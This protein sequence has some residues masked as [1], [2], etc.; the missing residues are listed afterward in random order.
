M[1]LWVMGAYIE[2]AALK[3]LEKVHNTENGVIPFFSSKNK[4]H[5]AMCLTGHSGS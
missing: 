3:T 4:V 1:G 2:I 5:T